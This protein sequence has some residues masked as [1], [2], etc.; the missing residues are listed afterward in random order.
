MV[1]IVGFLEIIKKQKRIIALSLFISVVA[2]LVALF[3]ENFRSISDCYSFLINSLI[4]F[5]IVFSVLIFFKFINKF[6]RELKENKALNNIEMFINNFFWFVIFPIIA[7][8]LLVYILYSGGWLAIIAILLIILILEITFKGLKPLHFIKILIK[9]TGSSPSPCGRVK[10]SARKFWEGLETK[11]RNSL[12][13]KF[14]LLVNASS[15]SSK[16][17]RPRDCVAFGS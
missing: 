13:V 9:L 11:S 16:R 5:L 17:T 14:F 3:D 7:L 12:F 1:Q 4:N 6:F 15:I 10:F 2:N 8:G